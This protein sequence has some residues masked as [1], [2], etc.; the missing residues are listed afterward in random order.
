MTLNV[1]FNLIKKKKTEIFFQQKE[2]N[3][4]AIYTQM[5]AMHNL[6]ALSLTFVYTTHERLYII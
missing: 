5:I 3:S 4:I 2:K 1:I 6:K